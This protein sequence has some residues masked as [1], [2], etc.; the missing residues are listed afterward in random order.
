MALL[1]QLIKC[2][3]YLSNLILSACRRIRTYLIVFNKGRYL[4]YG[5]SL[6]IG[7]N[8][9]LWAPD[10]IKIGDNVYIGKDVHI[11]C[12]AIIGDNTIIANRAAL[13]GRKDHDYKCIGTPVRFSPWIGLEQ[14]KSTYR[15]MV[16]VGD[17]VWIGFGVIILTGVKI[18]K[19][20]IIAAGSV[21]TKDVSSYSIVAGIP[22]KVINR[23][24]N[25]D[26]II[27]H[28]EM[29]N[30]GYFKYSMFGLDNSIISPGKL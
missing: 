1:N 22:A 11:E 2:L 17:D 12:N 30:S 9:R 29:I 23:R 18:G 10:H 14:N 5:S 28:E 15:D 8:V 16:Y 26:E 4:E 13:I 6:H 25:S 27:K 19:G 3:A 7:A 24:F 21:V 20:S